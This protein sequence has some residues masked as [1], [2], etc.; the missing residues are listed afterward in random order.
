MLRVN[1]TD[2]H[3]PAKPA[4]GKFSD[5]AVAVIDKR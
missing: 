3:S 2:S 4:S 5:V 1:N